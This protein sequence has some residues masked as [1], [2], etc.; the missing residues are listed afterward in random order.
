MEKTEISSLFVECFLKLCL[1]D[2]T[3]CGNIE[4]MICNLPKKSDEAS[5]AVFPY[6]YAVRK[7]MYFS[8]I[9]MAFQNQAHRHFF[10]K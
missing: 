5:Y 7:V 4:E 10:L 6:F 3:I 8:Y 1:N 2:E 9:T